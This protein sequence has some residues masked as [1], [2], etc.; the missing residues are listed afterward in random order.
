AQRSILL[1]SSA[2]SDPPKARSVPREQEDG[3]L[4]G[5]HRR[6][7]VDA[8]EAPIIILHAELIQKL[9]NTLP[10][11]TRP[12]IGQRDLTF[13]ILRVNDGPIIVQDEPRPIDGGKPDGVMKENEDR[14]RRLGTCGTRGRLNQLC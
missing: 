8:I 14:S 13:T 10:C 2:N 6:E 4:I 7:I 5:D 11:Y 12:L 1:Q 9:R 3:F